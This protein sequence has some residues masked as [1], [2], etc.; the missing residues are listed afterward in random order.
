MKNNIRHRD[1]TNNRSVIIFLKIKNS[2]RCYFAWENL[3]RG[4]CDVICC[5]S[6]HFDL[7]IVVVVLLHLSM[8]FI[9]LLLFLHSHFPFD[10][11]SHP[12]V[13]YHPVFTPIFYFQPSPSQSDS[14]HF[15]FSTIPLIFLPR[16]LRP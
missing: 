9:L 2:Q 11:I 16:V 8:F 7:H 14:R 5:S 4:F 15:R 1:N 10:V 12:S 6:F 13:D 3:Q